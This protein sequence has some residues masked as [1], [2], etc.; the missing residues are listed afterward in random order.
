MSS[1]PT[2]PLKLVHVSDIHFWQY[3][4]NPRRLFSK[5]LLG[6]AALLVRRARKFRLERVEE[7]V[8]RVLSLRPDHIVITGD[9]TTTALPAEFRAAK[10]ALGPWLVDPQKVT[11]L[12]G[13]HDRYT[14]RAHRDHRFEEF[15]GDFAPSPTYPWLRWLDGETAILA[16]DPTRAALT[17]R[18]RLPERQLETA[19]EVIA[20]ADSRFRRL[21]VACH[22]PVDAPSAFRNELAGKNLMHPDPLARWLS[23][24][25]PHLYCCGHV[26]AAWAFSPESIP[27]QLCLN[28][29]APLLRDRTG[30]RP[31]GFL[32][33][34][35]AGRDVTVHHHAWTGT[36]WEVVALHQSR[37]FFP[38]RPPAVV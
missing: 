10:R 14:V 33:I 20:R 22:Y 9:L 18:G 27:N 17:A 7:I 38:E 8:D 36:D 31:P 2:R 23:T 26:H 35:I 16:L 19:R 11:I 21:I 28:A 4:V 32:E 29:G 34:E 24:L 12:P 30:R 13:N 37:A 6:M 3:A 5:R 15:F 1:S 25:G